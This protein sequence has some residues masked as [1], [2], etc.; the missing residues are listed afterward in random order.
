MREYKEVHV[1]SDRI[2][3]QLNA[4]AREGAWS[5]VAFTDPEWM[6]IAGG[7]LQRRVLL[8]REKVAIVK[9]E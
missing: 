1:T 9:E 6:H 3:E 8:E 7:P 2:V 4:Q 5:F